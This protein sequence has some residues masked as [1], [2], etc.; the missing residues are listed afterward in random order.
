MYL[1]DYFP[2]REKSGNFTKNTGKIQEILT[3]QNWNQYVKSL[4]NFQSD[5]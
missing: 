4:G 2:V 5:K 1:G 3:L